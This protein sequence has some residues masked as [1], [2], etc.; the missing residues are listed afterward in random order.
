M[1]LR[2]A[3][4][5]LLLVLF[6]A[7]ATGA[8]GAAA[9]T[10]SRSDKLKP[11]VDSTNET[12]WAH[13][14]QLVDAQELPCPTDS[15]NLERQIILHL[16]GNGIQE[17][18]P[19]ILE[20]MVAASFQSTYNTLRFVSCDSLHFRSV[21]AANVTVT[22]PAPTVTSTTT[23]QSSV[24]ITLAI[25]AI[26]HNCTENLPLFDLEQQPTATWKATGDIIAPHIETTASNCMC[27]ADT[28]GQGYA[29][30]IYDFLP[31]LNSHLV[32]EL[33]ILAANSPAT[34]SPRSSI[35][36]EMY[37]VTVANIEELQE[38]PCSDDLRL[39]ES[40]VFSQLTVNLTLITLKEIQE[41]EQGFLQ[42]YN[43]LAFQTCDPWFRQLVGV[44]LRIAPPPGT[45]GAINASTAGHRLQDVLPFF[46]NT[47]NH[48]ASLSNEEIVP[49]LFAATV[50]CAECPVTSDGQFYLF[51]DSSSIQ[52]QRN[53]LVKKRS[54]APRMVAPQERNL[55]LVNVDGTC[56]C[57]SG[58]A[59]TL[60]QGP[61][62]D[63]FTTALTLEY[64]SLA[65][66]GI[67]TSV[68]TPANNV[69][70]GHQVTCSG[71]QM[72]FKTI[73]K[74]DIGRDLNA[75]SNEQK[76]A[77]ESVFAETYNGKCS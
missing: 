5:G 20:S 69:R 26:C 47:S 4:S 41:L 17:L 55:Q 2:L 36:P 60:G 63:A 1:M 67:V 16:E 35:S 57:P 61:T 38:F 46:G 23:T 51:D 21:T 44:E 43:S 3:Q 18:E 58:Q 68:I 50:S 12:P 54:K 49:T 31:N 13:R 34:V 30:N 71:Q 70:E 45:N 10:G 56:V 64:K 11:R 29:V 53:L 22:H 27:S 15:T 74:M 72:E 32:D 33:L 66:Q 76:H 19:S 77:I 7:T 75:L 42:A 39:F 6:S 65:E 9:D 59:P 62:A 48:N 25:Q 73:V 14:T 52:S 28:L 24:V 40:L 37:N 8:S